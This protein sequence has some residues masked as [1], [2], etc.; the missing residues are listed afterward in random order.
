MRSRQMQ[1]KYQKKREAATVLQ[2]RVRGINARKEWRRKKAAVVLL[3]AYTRGA[4]ARR[5]V[6]KM[7]TDVRWSRRRLLLK[8]FV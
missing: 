8:P 1:H 6:R 5:A 7:K 4:L 2:A 3:Q